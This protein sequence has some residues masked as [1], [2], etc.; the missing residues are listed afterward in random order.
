VIPASAVE[1]VRDIAIEAER[2]ERDVV[3]AISSGATPEEVARI[4]RPERW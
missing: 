3:A 1:A 2:A 4:L